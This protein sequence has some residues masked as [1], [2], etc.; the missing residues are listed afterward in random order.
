MGRDYYEILGVDRTA[1]EGTIKKAFRRKARELHPDVNPDPGAEAQFKEVATAYEALSN[2]E[3]RAVYD[4]YG[5]EGLRGQGATG[6]DF[7]G[8]ASFQ[9]L[10]DS[11]LGG[12]GFGGGGFG[13]GAAA[14]GDDIGIAVEIGFAESAAGVSRTL[15]YEVVA[16]CDTCEGTGAKPG[17]ELRT[18]TAC[19]GHGELRQVMRG[20]LGQF[21][22]AQ[23]CPQC[24][25]AGEMAEDP[26]ADCRGKGRRRSAQTLDIDIPAGIDHGQRI[27]VNG[28]GAAGPRGTPAGD[29]Y[30]Q[31]A[32]RE[33]KR[34]VRDGLDIVTR[35]A[36]PVTDAMVGATV[37]VPTVDGEAEVELRAGTQPGDEFVLRGRGFPAINGRGKGDQRVV[38]E[39]RVPRV[40]HE[41]GRRS[42]AQ[43]AEQLDARSYREDESFFDR[44]K[45]AFR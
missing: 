11:L 44:L 12:A 25:G 35:V 27:R 30:V 29:L 37:T 39:V 4:R 17:T 15:E 13:R 6:P 21:V 9:D 14:Q 32:V 18:C 19:G 40:Q 38:V 1:D 36:V 45:H 10:F 2:P 23:V 42:V 26:C 31:V 33:D 34:F 3:T 41:E 16:A 5:E 7:G 22:R 24:E 43:L 8:F 28:R 20:P